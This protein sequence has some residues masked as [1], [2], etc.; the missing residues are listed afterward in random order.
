MRKITFL[1]IVLC[2]FSILGQEKLTSA[3]DEH[4]DGSEWKEYGYHTYTYDETGNLVETNHYYWDWVESDWGLSSTDVFTYNENNKML[5]ESYESFGEE[6][7]STRVTYTYDVGGKITEQLEETKEQSVWVNKSKFDFGYSNDILSTGTKTDWDGS[8]WVVGEESGLYS[9]QY[10]PNGTVAFSIIEYQWDDQGS[11]WL[12][13]SRTAY[14]Y[15]ANDRLTLR[16]EQE[17][18]GSVWEDSGYKEEYTYDS[19]GNIINTKDYE[20]DVDKWVLEYEKTYSFDSNTLLSTYIH[21]F[22][23]S[24]LDA[25][26][27]ESENVNKVLSSINGDNNDRTTYHYSDDVANISQVNSAVIKVFPNPTDDFVTINDDYYSIKE[28]VVYNVVGEVV[29]VSSNTS[30]SIKEL[31]SGV[32][33]LKI[34]T[35]SGNTTRV[36]IMKK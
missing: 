36:K 32:Y 33:I 4:Y 11:T 3:T 1:F 16:A 5:T 13:K 12:S 21:P 2:S 9:L 26:L 29:K 34:E 30:F 20:Y 14:T 7:E 25:L 8:A 28:V 17:W 23:I 19:N 31:A 22:A 27:G 6:A 18:N 10:N 15:D 35:K 24:E